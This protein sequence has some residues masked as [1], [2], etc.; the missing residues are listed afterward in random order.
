M[1]ATIMQEAGLAPASD[2]VALLEPEPA[3]LTVAEAAAI[4]ADFLGRGIRR[5]NPRPWTPGCAGVVVV[6]RSCSTRAVIATPAAAI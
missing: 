1:A 5:A 3:T 4:V 2:L 6:G